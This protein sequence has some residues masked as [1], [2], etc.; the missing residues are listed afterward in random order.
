MVLTDIG[1]DEGR[2]ATAGTEVH[3]DGGI[4]GGAAAAPPLSS[5]PEGD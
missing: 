5:T 1:D 2:A 3:V 4:L